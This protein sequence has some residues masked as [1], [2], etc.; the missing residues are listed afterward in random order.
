MDSRAGD[1][2]PGADADWGFIETG[3][4]PFEPELPTRTI[5]ALVGLAI[6][7]LRVYR[8][9][10]QEKLE[11]LSGVDQTTISRLENAKRAGLSVRRLFAILRALRAEEITFGPGPRTVPQSSWEDVMYGDLWE[12]AGRVA[13]ARVNRRRSA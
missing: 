9:L 12:R 5:D 7:R 4:L 1:S 10:S 3:I 2:E 8:G 13:E 6:L 11:R